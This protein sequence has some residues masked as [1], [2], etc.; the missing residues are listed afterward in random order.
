M[1]GCDTD[2]CLIQ[3]HLPLRPR[4]EK[5]T[6]A[7]ISS[8]FGH[9][10]PPLWSYQQSWSRFVGGGPVDGRGETCT[11]RSQPPVWTLD[12]TDL[13]RAWLTRDCALLRSLHSPFAST[14]SL[15]NRLLWLCR[16]HTRSRSKFV[17][18]I[19]TDIVVECEKFIEYAKIITEI[20]TGPRAEVGSTNGEIDFIEPWLGP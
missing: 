1:S 4:Q 13:N 7:R 18:Q 12:P 6:G 14:L 8:L 16:M 2:P 3:M 11:T 9:G 17:R 20:V 5:G 10:I 19:A 15:L